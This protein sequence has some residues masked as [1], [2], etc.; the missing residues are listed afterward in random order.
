MSEGA[1][2]GAPKRLSD[3]AEISYRVS[4]FVGQE[5][6]NDLFTA[7]WEEYARRNF[8]PILRRSLV[9]VCAYQGERLVGFVNVAWDGGVHAFLLDTTVHPD[10]RRQG[11]GRDLVALAAEEARGHG[12]GWL[13]VDFEPHLVEFYRGCGFKATEAGLLDLG[14]GGS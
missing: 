9:Y 10:F 11:I 12:A 6:L 13:H 2:S 3:G 1:E 14:T 4:P 5:E 8:G 7:A